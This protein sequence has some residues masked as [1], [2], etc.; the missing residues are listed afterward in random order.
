M[1]K[2][3]LKLCFILIAVG[4]AS[5]NIVGQTPE[6]ETPEKAAQKAAESW[7]DVVDHYAY[8][9]TWEEASPSFKAVVNQD[10]W[11]RTLEDLRTR[12]GK[13]KDRKVRT[14]RY[15][16]SL[17]DAP[18]G[19]YVVVQFETTFQDNSSVIETVVPML[20][21]DGRWRVSGYY[22]KLA[23]KATEQTKQSPTPTP[24]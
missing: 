21:P 19:E 2:L 22:I 5:T 8:D 9:K 20:D 16:K 15:T 11:V 10:K 17:P 12:F 7:L 18:K 23:Q 24:N 14:A 6:K 1:N 3:L 4:L 13:V